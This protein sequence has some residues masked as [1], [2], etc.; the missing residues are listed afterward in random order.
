MFSVIEIEEL[1]NQYERKIEDLSE[2]KS[3]V[4]T[5]NSNLQN[6]NQE[7]IKQMKMKDKQMELKD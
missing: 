3:S 1:K 6:E 4:M 7:L 2:T 5:N